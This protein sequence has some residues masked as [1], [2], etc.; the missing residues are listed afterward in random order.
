MTR[1][2]RL[3]YWIAKSLGKLKVEN[4]GYELAGSVTGFSQ[5]QIVPLARRREGRPEVVTRQ[6]LA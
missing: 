4:A 2:G 3:K 5:P 6:R 1:P